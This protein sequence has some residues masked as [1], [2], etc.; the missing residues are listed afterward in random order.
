MNS[1]PSKNTSPPKL[2]KSSIP[3]INYNQNVTLPRV[4]NTNNN[5]SITGTASSK[6]EFKDTPETFY[7]FKRTDISNIANGIKPDKKPVNKSH[8]VA[9]TFTT[10]SYKNI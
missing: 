10:P 6:V 1:V 9:K 2:T 3:P 4:P 7:Q 5:L 8:S